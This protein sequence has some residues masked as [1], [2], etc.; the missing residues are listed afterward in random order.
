MQ[1]HTLRLDDLE[2]FSFSTSDQVDPAPLAMY[3]GTFTEFGP[4]CACTAA[5]IGCKKN[6]DGGGGW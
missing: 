4:T 1:K 5:G 6:Q 2:V 3:V